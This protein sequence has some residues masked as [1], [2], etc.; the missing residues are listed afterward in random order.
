MNFRTF[1]RTLG[2]TLTTGQDRAVAVSFDGEP[3]GADELG[4]AL[5][6][7]E[8]PPGHREVVAWVKGARIG[9]T[10]LGAYRL[11]HLGL[12]VPLA[13]AP[14]ESAFGVI[15]APDLRLA[16]QAL[17]YI[18]GA[19]HGTHQLRGRVL[20]ETEDT[21]V[22]RR[23]DGRAV[24]FECLPATRGGSALRG[25][26]LVG[27]LLS[28]AAFFRDSDSVVNDAELF[29]AVSPRVV[30][31]GQVI[32]E[33]TPWVESGLLFDLF[34][35]H[36]GHGGRTLAVHAPTLLLR[37]DPR[38]RAMVLA[39]EARDPENAAREFGAQFLGGGAGT[40]FDPSTIDA[41]G[42]DS[43][44][45]PS[46]P[47]PGEVLGGGMDLGLS[48]DSA[49]LAIAGRKE[50][51]YR[52]LFLRE[53]RPGRGAPLKLSEVLATFAEDLAPYK[54]REVAADAWAR[55]P[56]KEWLDL[57]KIRIVDAPAGQAAKAESFISLR[58]LLRENRL[59]LP[60]LPRLF[61][62]LKAVVGKP[63]PGGGLA[64]SIPRRA[65]MSHGD[66][67]SALVLAV[68]RA[69]QGGDGPGLIIT[70]G[71][72]RHDPDAFHGLGTGRGF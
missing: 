35:K 5:F 46:L 60:K 38:T 14:G 55:E 9:G 64:I 69:S 33:S 25:R 56:A 11:L 4:L 58:T 32:L 28:E 71:R 29:R 24:T 27:A 18:K 30:A 16:R 31:G 6:G 51:L 72:G 17:R 61:A 42:E 36:H 3:S 47:G 2:L 54:I 52:L 49:A 59:A 70:G 68:W 20:Q 63:V 7:A 39:E 37:D 53:L 8:V 43:L 57:H 34:D 21:L 50:K 22:L 1:L 19:V 41:A 10:M 48:R 12:T 26:S 65:G 15:V 44:L 62:Q 45:L 67:V 66:D 40:F 13:L 23:D